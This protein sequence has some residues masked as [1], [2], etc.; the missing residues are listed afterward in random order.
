MYKR[1]FFFSRR[2]INH[3]NSQSQSRSSWCTN[4]KFVEKSNYFRSRYCT[5]RSCDP[6]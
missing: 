3:C 5:I 2:C 6:S 1:Q 4:R